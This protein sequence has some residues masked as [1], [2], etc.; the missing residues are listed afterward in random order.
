MVSVVTFD[1]S[2]ESSLFIVFS[3]LLLHILHS[4]SAGYGKKMPKAP[5]VGK[6][7]TPKSAKQS[8]N[9][10]LIPIMN[11]SQFAKNKLNN[12][13]MMAVKGG[14]R[15]DCTLVGYFFGLPVKDCKTY[16]NGGCT[17]KVG[18]SYPTSPTDWGWF[19]LG[20]EA[21]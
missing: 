7:V 10:Y 16:S 1:R 21:C 9:L 2:K 15:E 14:V 8:R 4:Y 6:R 17:H 3:N 20:S 19:E 5:H 12:E 11:F 18:I 13:Q